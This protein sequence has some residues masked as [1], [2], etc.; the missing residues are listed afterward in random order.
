MIQID[1]GIYEACMV[2]LRHAQTNPPTGAPPAFYFK[3]AEKRLRLAMML[4]VTDE[5]RQLTDG[6]IAA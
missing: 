4:S 2:A 3:S 6:E 1:D 5:N